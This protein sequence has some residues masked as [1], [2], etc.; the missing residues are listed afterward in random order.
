MPHLGHH[1]L[2]STQ[3]WFPVICPCELI[4]QDGRYVRSWS[5]VPF[6]FCALK[7]SLLDLKPR[8]CGRLSFLPITRLVIETDWP[9][10]RDILVLPLLESPVYLWWHLHCTSVSSWHFYGRWPL[11]YLKKGTD[12]HTQSN[13]LVGQ[14][15]NPRYFHTQQRCVYRSQLKF[16][17][18]MSQIFKKW[19]LARQ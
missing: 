16:I 17:R 7:Y 19:Y 14:Y 3:R 2:Y 13:A 9:L 10:H 11:R 1:W 12:R 8:V 18:R 4:R 15:K 6:L 5:C